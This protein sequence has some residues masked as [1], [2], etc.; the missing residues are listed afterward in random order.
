MF[1]PQEKELR[2]LMA[3]ICD[4]NRDRLD[5]VQNRWEYIYNQEGELVV[6]LPLLDIIYK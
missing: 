2:Y 1:R 6:A 5:V 3:Y 4:T